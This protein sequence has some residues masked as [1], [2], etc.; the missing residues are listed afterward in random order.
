MPVD[1]QSSGVE[2]PTPP[3]CHLRRNHPSAMTD[4]V[5]VLDTAQRRPPNSSAGLEP[6]TVEWAVE[7]GWRPHVHN[8]VFAGSNRL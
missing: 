1:G 8:R 5:C 3:Q 7:P 4:D 2:L 6:R